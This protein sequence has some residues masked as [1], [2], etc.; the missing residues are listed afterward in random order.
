VAEYGQYK[1][2]ETQQGRYLTFELGGETFGIDIVAV[3]TIVGM[4]PV[5]PVP[6]VPAYVKGVINLRGRIIPVID[7]RLRFGR[8]A[9]E[10][11]DRACI[12]VVDE[13]DTCAGLIVDGV[14]EVAV[15]DDK[16]IVPP[17]EWKAGAQACC[18]KAIGKTGGGVKLLL[19]CGKLLGGEEPAAGS[20]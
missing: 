14:S 6:G 20:Q 18:V 19:D 17:P 11:G 2:E 8:E 9:A 7:M 1:E 13:Q 16:D 4:Q 10:Y 3:T 5:T 15:I 12:V